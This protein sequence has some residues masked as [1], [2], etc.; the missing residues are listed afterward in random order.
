MTKF[1]ESLSAL[2]HFWPKE[3]PDNKWPG[4]VFLDTFP[5]AKVHCIG[6]RPGDGTRPNGRMIVHGLTDSNE[7]ITMLEATAR[8]DSS[9]F[10]RASSTESVAFTA[11]QMLV[12]SEHFDEGPSVTRLS[13]SSSM[14]EHVLRLRARPD[15]KD[16]RHR[17]GGLTDHERPILRKQMASYVNRERK[18]RFRIFRSAV[19]SIDI[20]PMSSLTVDFADPVTPKHAISVLHEFRSFLTLI[21][22][23]LVDFW[24]VR[25]QHKTEA[26]RSDSDVYFCDPV[27]RPL[28]GDRFPMRP[29]LNIGHDRA[30]FRRIVSGWLAEPRARRIARG[31]LVLIL[32][33]KGSLRLSHL[34]DLV[35]MIEMLAGK[36]GASPLSGEEARD[37]RSALIS[38][39]EAFAAGKPESDSWLGTMKK[40]IDNINSHD[41]KI[42]VESFISKLP[43][44]LVSVPPKFSSDVV[45]LRNAL[46][47]DITRVQIADYN[48]L[49]FFV[50]KLKGLYALSDAIA[51]GARVD[52][53]GTNSEFLRLADQM[54]MNAF[55][56]EEAANADGDAT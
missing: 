4:K 56:D 49:A 20:E 50:A 42:K 3:K 53:I 43:G 36:E 47:H 35:T 16:I 27:K 26:G 9:S 37:L 17:K 18:I 7:Y 8:F 40:R 29:I 12:G 19:P 45:E 48:K 2:G 23:D 52:E 51:L 22:G 5:S 15:Y 30:L 25:F 14:V 39:L 11:N 21:C 10:N 46:V 6:R 33:D 28:K 54:P 41:A 55:S 13:F 32:R 44:G 24:D 34:R 1:K 38:T 31:A